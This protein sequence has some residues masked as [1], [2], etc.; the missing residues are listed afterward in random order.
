MIKGIIIFTDIAGSS[1][2][3]NKYK[4]NFYK[5]L[6]ELNRI[7][8]SKI[9]KYN[10]MIVKLLGDSHM[11]FFDDK[12]ILNSLNFV[13]ELQMTLFNKNLNIN[14]DKIQIRIGYSY[15]EM[16]KY[17]NKV[18]SCN[19]IDFYGNNVNMASRLESLISS[20]GG[21]AI[22]F[23]KFENYFNHLNPELKEFIKKY[24]DNQEIDY[25]INNRNNRN[26]RN[27]KKKILS[28]NNKNLSSS[29]I[30]IKKTIKHISKT[31][32]LKKFKG[33]IF[34]DIYNFKLK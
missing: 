7:I 24:Y 4:N 6:R 11:I 21:I 27:N 28:K 31:K 10:G 8:E 32:Q 12:N 33:V 5:K 25:D 9:K 1:K 14:G 19:L 20:N 18:Q 34:D 23:N 30:K 2:L 17:I 26:N 16:N 22:H 13:F 15:G 29:I 3:W